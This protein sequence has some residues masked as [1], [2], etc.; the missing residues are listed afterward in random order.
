M[1]QIVANRCHTPEST[2]CLCLSWCVAGVS[3]M[4]VCFMVACV[5]VFGPDSAHDGSRRANRRGGRWGACAAHRRP[6]RAICG[7]RISAGLAH[8]RRRL[9]GAQPDF[10]GL[11]QVN[12]RLNANLKGSGEV[13]IMT[14]VDGRSSN[15]VTVS[16][17]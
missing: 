7:A 3:E 10:A 16:I 6:A 2:P 1:A 11:D 17:K 12:V 14:I 8:P 4:P 5:L 15:S 13:T 9:R